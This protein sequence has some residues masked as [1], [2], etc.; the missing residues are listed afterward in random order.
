MTDTPIIVAYNKSPDFLLL[1]NL[2]HQIR[3]GW[4]GQQQENR[5]LRHKTCLDTYPRVTIS[6]FRPSP[7]HIFVYVYVCVF[8]FQPEM[9]IEFLFT[10]YLANE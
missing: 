6:K 2:R 9:P 7:K 5:L 8:G 1:G 3:F 4:I 10:D